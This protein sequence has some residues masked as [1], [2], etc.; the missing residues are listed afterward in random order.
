M[1][2]LRL[3]ERVSRSAGVAEGRVRAGISL[4]R[5]RH[6]LHFV[7]PR[8]EGCTSQFSALFLRGGKSTYSGHQGSLQGTSSAVSWALHGASARLSAKWRR[9]SGARSGRR[10]T[11]DCDGTVIALSGMA[12]GE[13]EKVRGRSRPGSVVCARWGRGCGGGGGRGRGCGLQCCSTPKSYK[14]RWCEGPSLACDTTRSPSAPP[15]PVYRLY[16]AF[17]WIYII[18]FQCC[19]N[20]IGTAMAPKHDPSQITSPLEVARQALWIGSGS[21]TSFSLF[22]VCLFIFCMCLLSIPS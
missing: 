8:A 4:T 21:G 18:F 22:T 14:V 13:G 1:C 20:G 2:Y 9:Q 19:H 12:R 11:H 5:H 7:G 16:I 15:T 10:P 6:V 17:S 3:Y